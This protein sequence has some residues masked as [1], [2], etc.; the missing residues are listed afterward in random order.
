[1]NDAYCGVASVTADSV[2]L[3]TYF[4]TLYPTLNSD[5]SE[6]LPSGYGALNRGSALPCH[7]FHRA[8]TRAATVEKE[9][10]AAVRSVGLS[11]ALPPSNQPFYRDEHLYMDCSNNS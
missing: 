1:V 9:E 8:S 2:Q 11:L 4:N 7:L 10:N 5:L 6:Y 3:G